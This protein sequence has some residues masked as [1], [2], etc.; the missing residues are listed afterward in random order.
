MKSRR[1]VR[2]NSYSKGFNGGELFT[3]LDGCVAAA[4][5]V[6]ATGAEVDG[7]E[8]LDQFLIGLALFQKELGFI[9]MFSSFGL[10]WK[11]S[12]LEGVSRGGF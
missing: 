9:A 8:L 3:D 10:D 12:V 5:G 11:K 2:R 7:V 4:C 1:K 6:V